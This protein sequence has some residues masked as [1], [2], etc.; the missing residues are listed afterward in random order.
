MDN[1]LEFKPET[2]DKVPSLYSLIEKRFGYPAARSIL[3]SM[4]QLAGIHRT[5]G[6]SIS[7]EDRLAY[8][9]G[10][11]KYSSANAVYLEAELTRAELDR[12]I[13]V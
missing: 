10:R 5:N 3:L 7:Y 9:L 6:C 4:E 1:I 2:N 11:V 12:K 13:C 8:A